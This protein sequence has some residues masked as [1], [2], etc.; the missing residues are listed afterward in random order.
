VTTHIEQNDLFLRNQKC[1][2]DA[3]VVSETDGVATGKLAAQGMELQMRLKRV[4]L[5]VFEQPCKTWLQIGM[6]LEEFSGMTE[7][8]PGR[9][10]IIHYSGS[11]VSRAFNNSPAVLNT[12]TLPLSMSSR[13]ARTRA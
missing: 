7:K 1:K 13:D 4:R 9:D 10:K 11:S 8:L 6:F 2:S 5:Q 12:F 3:I